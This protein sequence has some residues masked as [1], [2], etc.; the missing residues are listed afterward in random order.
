ML[1]GLIVKIESELFKGEE[2]LAIPTWKM[3]KRKYLSLD[4]LLRSTAE[5]T[6]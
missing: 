1:I 2:E 5:E 4:T 3:P 6:G